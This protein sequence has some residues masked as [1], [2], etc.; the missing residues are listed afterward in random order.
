MTQEQKRSRKR[1]ISESDGDDKD[2]SVSFMFRG[3]TADTR[4]FA[5]QAILVFC[6]HTAATPMPA[7]IFFPGLADPGPDTALPLN[8]ASYQGLVHLL[9]CLTRHDSGAGGRGGATAL[10]ITV[11][12][13]PM[14]NVVF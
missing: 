1:P 9:A 8:Y 12:G 5:W 11:A 2:L 7:G 13:Q 3:G 6:G 4:L 10:E 14:F